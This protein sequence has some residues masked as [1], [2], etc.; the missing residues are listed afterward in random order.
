M[1]TRRAEMIAAYK[2]WRQRPPPVFYETTDLVL[3]KEQNDN[4]EDMDASDVAELTN[5]DINAV[6]AMMSLA[7]A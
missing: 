3:T 5:D 2:S 4:M 1:P 6:E 7:S